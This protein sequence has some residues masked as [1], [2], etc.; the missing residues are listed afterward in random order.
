MESDSDI[1]SEGGDNDSLNDSPPFSPPPSHVHAHGSAI[2]GGNGIGGVGLLSDQELHTYL[3]ENDI[4]ILPQA[5]Q[6][7]KKEEPDST[8]V[9]FV[10]HL[11]LV[12]HLVRHSGC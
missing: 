10:R 4:D 5:S 8:F 11:L 12:R 1:W 2:S 9:G 3:R 6:E 7:E